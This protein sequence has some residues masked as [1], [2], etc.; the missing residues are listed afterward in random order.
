MY[1]PRAYNPKVQ[2]KRTRENDD[3]VKK[4]IAFFNEI[5]MAYIEK[6]HAGPGRKGRVDLTGSLYG[7][8]VEIE[9]KAPGKTP[10]KLQWH[11]IMHWAKLGCIS[12]FCTDIKTFAAIFEKNGYPIIMEAYK[13]QLK[14]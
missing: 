2:G 14:A 10:T 8:R 11:W 1:D 13:K 3:V 5:P 7:R 12:G 6:R 9:V 4:I